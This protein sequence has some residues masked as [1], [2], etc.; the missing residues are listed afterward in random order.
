M[1][2]VKW[3]DNIISLLIRTYSSAGNQASRTFDIRL[4]A[5]NISLFPGSA[6]TVSLPRNDE[7]IATLVPRDALILLEYEIS[8]L[9]VA[10]I[11]SYKNTGQVGLGMDD[12]ISVVR[13]IAALNQVVI[14]G[15]EDL[16]NGQKLR[17][18]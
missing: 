5:S 18:N 4:D 3:K 8:I 14:R 11:I 17:V 10:V 9:K 1:V 7:A 15:G 16:S 6:V 13:N 12:W 2:L